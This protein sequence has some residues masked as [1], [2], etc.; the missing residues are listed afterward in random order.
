[1][2]RTIVSVVQVRNSVQEAVRHAMELVSWR[3][4][5]QRNRPTALKV[6]LGWELFIPGSITSPWISP[7]VYE[8]MP[9]GSFR[10]S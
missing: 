2:S 4:V 3:N 8:L 7:Q 5:L 9:W 1:M 6:N 10:I